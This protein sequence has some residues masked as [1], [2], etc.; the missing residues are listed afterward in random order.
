MTFPCFVL[1]CFS[2]AECVFRRHEAKLDLVFPRQDAAAAIDNMVWPRI[3]TLAEVAFGWH[4]GSLCI[5]W[6]AELPE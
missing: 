2:V 3:L 4:R 6:F 1:L 5:C